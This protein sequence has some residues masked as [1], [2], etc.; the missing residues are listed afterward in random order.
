MKQVNE[1]GWVAVVAPTEFDP[2]FD[3]MHQWTTEGGAIECGRDHL[4]TMS[5]DDVA[6]DEFWVGQVCHGD[7]MF[8]GESSFSP[9]FIN[10]MKKIT[11]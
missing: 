1:G 6:P 4:K 9:V 11:P 3:L 7:P 8:D 10:K 2:V 5:D